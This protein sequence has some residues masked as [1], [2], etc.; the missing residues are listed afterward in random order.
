MAPIIDELRETYTGQLEVVFIDIKANPDAAVPYNIRLIPT[1][2]FLDADGNELFRH[3][4]F[5]AREVIL[6]KWTELGYDFST[7]D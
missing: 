5:Y 4:G 3:E 6:A 1:Q 7:I 2:V